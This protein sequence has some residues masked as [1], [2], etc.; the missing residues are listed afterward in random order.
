MSWLSALA[1]LAKVL[2]A[3][4]DMAREDQAR[5]TGRAEAIAEASTHALDLIRK[6]RDARRA[7]ADAAAD[8]ARLRDDD[9]FRRD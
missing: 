9:G 4:F 5:G 2:T 1:A 3:I 6:A 7:A 8:P